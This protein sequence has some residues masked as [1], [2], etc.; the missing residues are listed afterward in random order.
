[1]KTPTLAA[2]GEVRGPAQF[3][4]RSAVTSPESG[5]RLTVLA[6]D[7]YPAGRHGNDRSNNGA[8]LA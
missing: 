5:D 7:G 2:E 1:M 3:L 8:R 4:M 6:A